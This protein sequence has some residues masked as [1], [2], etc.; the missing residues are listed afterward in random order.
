MSNSKSF[1]EDRLTLVKR[2][3]AAFERKYNTTFKHLQEAGLPD[4]AS[5]KMHEDFIEWAGWQRTYEETRS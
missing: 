3:I 4:D 1:A 2:K 5:L